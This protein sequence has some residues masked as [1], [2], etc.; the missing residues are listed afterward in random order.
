MRLTRWKLMA[1]VLGLSMCGL[2]ALAEPAC[3]SVGITRRDE[4]N[5]TPPEAAKPAIPPL[6]VAVPSPP[7]ATEVP[8][9]IPLV[10]DKKP[11]ETPLPSL[12]PVA[13]KPT[14]LKPIALPPVNDPTLPAAVDPKLLAD[15]HKIQNPQ[16]PLPSIDTKLEPVAPLPKPTEVPLQPLQNRAEDLRN[17]A[18]LPVIPPKPANPDPV[19]VALPAP[20]PVDPIPAPGFVA[21]PGVIPV[22][23]AKPMP[24]VPTPVPVVTERPASVPVAA[25][26]IA[27][28]KLKVTL[29]LSDEK[30]WFEIKDSDEVVLKVTAD[31]VQLVAASKGSPAN[32][33]TAVGGVTFRT[34]GGFGT[35]D[36]LTV[37][38]GT[39]E[40]VVTGKVSVTSNWGKSETTA[41]AD[42]MTFRLGSEPKK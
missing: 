36:E 33:L 39:G 25:G 4:P 30:P 1:G 24:V 35:C 34:L 9:A 27:N 5:P 19:P 10:E 17:T 28:K 22:A 42:K 23:D 21:V 7:P 26:T 31:G 40:V 11:A 29:H 8:A 12:P 37:V 14:E 2:A 13:A 32:T 41:T 18:P 6:P 38:P 3:R 20:K 16:T 15:V